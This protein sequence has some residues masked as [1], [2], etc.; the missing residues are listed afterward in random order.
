MA[1]KERDMAT[2]TTIEHGVV[3]THVW[4]CD[5]GDPDRRGYL[6][7]VRR[8]TIGEVFES[9]NDE[10]GLG[11]DEF[12]MQELPPGLDEYFHPSIHLE[13][14]REWPDGRMSVYAVTGGSEGHYVHVDVSKHPVRET[15]FL[16]KTFAGW[17]AAWDAAKLIG[18]A[19]G[20]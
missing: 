3:S 15:L 19:L 13:E 10:L 4:A 8:L 7:M 16:G 2:M 6:R 12:G 11:E 17:D 5:L 18:H 1:G 9:L 20:V 14:E